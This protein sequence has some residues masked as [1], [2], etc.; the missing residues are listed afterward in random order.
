M[1]L[2]AGV[3]ERE[4]G[5]GLS[6]CTGCT[7]GSRRQ[8]PPNERGGDRNA[9]HHHF[10]PHKRFLA[11]VTGT[12]SWL[13]SQR[14]S[15]A[16]ARRIR[17]GETL[18]MTAANFETLLWWHAALHENGTNFSVSKKLSIRFLQNPFK[19]YGCEAKRPSR[20]S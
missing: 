17:V 13:P 5:N 19:I 16:D 1:L 11:G 2:A 18:Q 9:S 4:P 20:V 10:E 3:F 6:V 12:H 14:T 7:Q 15:V 8:Q